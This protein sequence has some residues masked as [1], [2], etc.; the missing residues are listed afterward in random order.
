MSIEPLEGQLHAFQCCKLIMVYLQGAFIYLQGV[1]KEGEFVVFH[2][3][4]CSPSCLLP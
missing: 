1:F 2:K 3:L 4:E